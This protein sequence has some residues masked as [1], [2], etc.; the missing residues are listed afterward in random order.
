MIK[1]KIFR[2]AFFILFLFF[3]RMCFAQTTASELFELGQT[4]E[5]SGDKAKAID[6]YEKSID[7]DADFAPA[8]SALAL[9]YMDE[10]KNLDDVVWLFSQA[11]DLEPQNA[12]H[13]TNMCRA[14]F[15]FQKYDW[16]EAACLKA[17]S[18]DDHSIGAKMT[19]AWVYLFGKAQPADAVKYF[20]QIVEKVPNPKVYY[21]LGMAYARNN[22]Q[23]NALDI[24]TT[25]RGMGEETLASQLE[26]MIRSASSPVEPMPVSMANINAGPSQIVSDKPALPVS[27][28]TSDP[29]SAG[30]I[31]IQL[32]ARLPSSTENSATQ[33][34]KPKLEDDG[35]DLEDYKPLTLKERQER[36]KRMR[37]NTGT[38]R[39]RGTV[40]TQT[41][42]AR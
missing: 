20:K 34:S 22:E 42:S 25:L 10:N 18:I 24:I 33:K 30:K 32:K 31:R 8:Y 1:I 27:Q 15:Q 6:F 2:I 7:A 14:Y 23:A 11:A 12:A 16:A 3:P 5:S 36:V 35:Y 38:A 29:Q 17:L 13:Y 4:A 40:S 41:R 39:G 26:K 19:L 9:I 21:G 28:P 37:G